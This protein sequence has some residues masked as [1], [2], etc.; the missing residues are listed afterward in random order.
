[1]TD[2]E[3]RAF[4]RGIQHGVCDR[5]VDKSVYCDELHDRV[6]TLGQIYNTGDDVLQRSPL[7]TREDRDNVMAALRE[8]EVELIKCAVPVGPNKLSVVTLDDVLAVNS[9][10]KTKYVKEAVSDV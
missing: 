9:E 10:L 1:M 2:K 3:R 8:L 6:V 5:L 4:V 7:V